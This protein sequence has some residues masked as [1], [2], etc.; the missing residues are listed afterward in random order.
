MRRGKGKGRKK[1]DARRKRSPGIKRRAAP[2]RK[3]KKAAVRKKR[4]TGI[5]T[6]ARAF[7][8]STPIYYINDEPH[9]GHFYCTAAAD[10]L[11]R[12]HRLIGDDVF[13]VTGTDENSQK[14]VQAAS[15]ANMDIRQFTDMMSRKW[16]DAWKK[17]GISNDF[18]I[19][20]TSPAHRESVK[21][22]LLK[23]HE[24][25]DIY[26]KDYEGLYCV[27]CEK[28]LTDADMAEGLCAVH[29][30]KP[31][32]VREENYF[33][34]LSKY[35]S[36]LTA[37]LKSG[38]FALPEARRNEM[39]EFVKS[40]LQD[41][42]I[43]RAKKDWGIPLP[44]DE[45][46]V[47][48]VWFD[49]LINYISALGYDR[50]D[51]QMARYWRHAI[52]LVGK[53]I[54]RFHT[55]MWPAMLMSAGLPVPKQVF[56]HGFFTINGEKI[57]K[58]LGNAI[59]PVELAKKYSVDAIKYFMMKEIPFGTDS[60]FSLKRLEDRYK[61]DLSDDLGNLL[62]RS[63]IMIEKYTLGTV[64]APDRG[65]HEQPLHRSLELNAKMFFKDQN[66]AKDP[67]RDI[68]NYYQW[69]GFS[70]IL[71]H[72]WDYIRSINKYIDQTKPWVLF[73]ENR[74]A[75]LDTVLY[76]II[77]AMKIIAILLYPVMPDTANRIFSQIGLDQKVEKTDYLKDTKWG[78]IK[79]GLKIKRGELLFPPLEEKDM[80]EKK[81]I[82]QKSPAQ[83]GPEA[84]KKESPPETGA[85]G[86][87]SIDHFRKM[88]LRVGEVLSAEKVPDTEKLLKLE[89]SLGGEKRI[90]LAGIA[91][92]YTPEELVGKKVVVVK[93]LEPRKMR[94]IESQGMLLA[95]SNDAGV[96]SVLTVHRDIAA[97]S[98]V[99]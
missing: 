82:E 93:N 37:L 33:F 61:G 40:G 90:I 24:K 42:S 51:P 3:K 20:T 32:P 68:D 80:E 10:I 15:R 71:G 11:A 70:L 8:I 74:K 79:P 96:L 89:V 35:G 97:G 16:I 95:A 39:L 38:F 62:N 46:H 34:R 53:D 47:V 88:D 67:Q 44:I 81:E 7:Y 91:Q 64:P 63:L 92:H 76:N 77:Q 50:D 66:A 52:H 49:A 45:S 19:R 78:T 9:I 14:T 26:K 94:G 2:V 21:K 59:D 98:R 83:A 13:F 65:V 6:R 41:I 27:G 87:I 72:L 54:F 69:F 75:E 36:R 85:A 43:S 84:I 86:L 25:G 28:F 29:K 99:S 17:L 22:L 48:Y 12:Y 5:R 58:S 4:G 23:C 73:K 60:D 31:E 57:S 55:I 18:F 30:T 1:K 56:G